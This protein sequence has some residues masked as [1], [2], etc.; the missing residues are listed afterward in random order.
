LR[1]RILGAAV[2]IGV[3][4]FVLLPSFATLYTDWL[5]FGEVGHEQVFIR[6]FSARLLLGVV[7]FAIV[8]GAL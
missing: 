5:W 7:A 1:N 2:V 6:T 4:L 8:F 3:V